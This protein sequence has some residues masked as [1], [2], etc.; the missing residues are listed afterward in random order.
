MS[1]VHKETLTIVENAL[2]NRSDHNIE[3]FGMEGIPDDIVAQHNQRVTQQFY[4]AEADRRA[5]TGNPAP[6]GNASA[7]GGPKKPKIESVSEMKKRLAEHKARKAAQE[8]DAAA[9]TPTSS[10]LGAASPGPSHSPA[11]Y[12]SWLSAVRRSSGLQSLAPIWITLSTATT[13]I[14]PTRHFSTAAARVSTSS[15]FS[16]WF[17]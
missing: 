12:V 7:A 4:Q 11:P 6:G 13:F 14:Y 5:S 16:I 10:G 9:G 1:Q 2:P 17:S 3:I 15:I 8:A